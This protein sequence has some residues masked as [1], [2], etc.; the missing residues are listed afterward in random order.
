M[1]WFWYD[2]GLRHERVNSPN[3]KRS[4]ELLKRTTK[5]VNRHFKVGLLWKDNFSILQKNHEL[6]IQRFESLEKRFLKDP[7]FFNMYRTQI[8]DYITSGQA[9][10]LSPEEK[11]NTS[12][13]TNCIS[14][15]VVSNVT[16]PIVSFVMLQ[17]RS[18]KYA[19]TII[20]YQVLIC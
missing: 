7:E 15:S 13:T 3:E 18:T 6:A 12:S 4:L 2:I 17:P 10:L 14:H 11:N 1:D 9:K 16:S 20:S 19:Q 5:F 8:S